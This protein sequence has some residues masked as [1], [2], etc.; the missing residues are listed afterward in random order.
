MT[1]PRFT[2]N[3]LLLILIMLP[4][5]ACTSSQLGVPTS[6]DK[7]APPR[8]ILLTVENRNAADARIYLV[9][10]GIRLRLG[11]VGS[12]ER[13]TL[14]LPTAYLGIPGGAVLETEL[15]ASRER[16][17]MQPIAAVSG[18]RVAWTIGHRLPYSVVSVSR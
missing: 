17:A 2:P 6:L 16:H 9:R 3:R 4:L 10:A 15:M 1:I 11:T 13:R 18:D 5:G 12:H 8:G 7:S 14:S